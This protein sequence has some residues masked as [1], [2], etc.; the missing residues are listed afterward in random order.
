MGHKASGSGACPAFETNSSKKPG[1]TRDIRGCQ[2]GPLLGI[3]GPLI[4]YRRLAFLKQSLSEC[5]RSR[6]LNHNWQFSL[7]FLIVSPF[8]VLKGM[9]VLLVLFLHF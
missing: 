2:L 1:G 6:I 4:Q 8:F 7:P 9:F 5:T 3:V